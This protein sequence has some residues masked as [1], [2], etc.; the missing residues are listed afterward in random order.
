MADL[1]CF[2]VSTFSNFLAFVLVAVHTVN[3]LGDGHEPENEGYE[4]DLKN[5]FF[6]DTKEIPFLFKFVRCYYHRPKAYFDPR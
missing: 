5:F 3:N 1:G 6:C 4:S 2:L